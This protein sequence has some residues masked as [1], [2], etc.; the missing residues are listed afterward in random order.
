[1]GDTADMS[2]WAPVGGAGAQ[3]P[4]AATRSSDW[5][6]VRAGEGVPSV[7]APAVTPATAPTAPQHEVTSADSEFDNPL[8]KAVGYLGGKANQGI[9]AATGYAAEKAGQ[10]LPKPLATIADIALTYPA[11]AASLL[12]K[13]KEEAAAGMLGSVKLPEMGAMLSPEAAAAAKE[14]AEAAKIIRPN[15]VERGA[16]GIISAT[17]RAPERFT[18]AW[19]ADPSVLGPETPTPQAVGKKMQAYFESKGVKIDSQKLREITGRDYVPNDNQYEALNKDFVRPALDK[20]EA[21]A[22]KVPGA[23]P[24]TEEE[25]IFAERA[26]NAMKRSTGAQQ[27]KYIMSY[28]SGAQDALLDHLD[29]AGFGELPAL[30]NE[31]FR[32]LAKDAAQDFLPRNKTGGPNALSTLLMG[33]QA[34]GAVSELASGNLGA[35]AGKALQAAAFSPMLVGQGIRG[36]SAALNPAVSQPLARATSLIPAA[37]SSIKGPEEG[38]ARDVLAYIKAQGGINPGKSGEFKSTLAGIPGSSYVS[39]HAKKSLQEIAEARGMDEADILKLLKQG[40]P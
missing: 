6:P 26:A 5:V 18:S 39:G 16:G 7:F 29:K 21:V 13:N 20:I 30:K 9:Q 1:M 40:N 3:A 10:Y 11:T 24:P 8:F 28:A 4:A 34:V 17:T 15:T 25:V 12:P 2:D 35:A 19:V 22:N 33:K 32:A 37:L 36:V 14:A 31:Y 27:N 23:L 38:S